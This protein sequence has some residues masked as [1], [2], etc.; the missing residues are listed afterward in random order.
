M[1]IALQAK[2]DELERRIGMLESRIRHL[3]AENKLLRQNPPQPTLT[4]PEKR[5]SA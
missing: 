4:L 5:K 3:E 2:V 1:S